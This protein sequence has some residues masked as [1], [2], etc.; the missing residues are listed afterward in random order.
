MPLFGGAPAQKESIMDMI[1]L[2]ASS[3]PDFCD[4]PARWEAK[5]IKG[6]R[7]PTSY[8]AYL[9]TCVHAGTAEYDLSKVNGATAS[10]KEL[11]ESALEV[12]HGTL[13][14]PKEDIE[15]DDAT[16]EGIEPIVL[17]LV[18]MYIAQIAPKMDYVAV[19]ATCKDLPL[20]DLG[21]ILTGTTDRI[22]QTAADEYGIADLK[23]GGSAVASDG[24]V[25]TTPHAMQMGVYEVLAEASTGLPITAPAHII[26]L[27]TAKTEKGRRVGIGTIEGAKD[28]LLGSAEEPGVLE[29]VSRL[30]HSGTFLGNPKS[31][32]CS[33]KFCPAY[34]ACRFRH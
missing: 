10:D 29:I 26:G 12:A 7:N 30:I 5:Y 31:S 32:V 18:K 16:P 34:N 15:W 19:E 14:A 17:S 33:E 4:C 8:K 27:Q 9:G 25:K 13:Y 23:T 3:L 6:M 24:T 28:M 21:L 2:R 22:Y 1:K 20:E 11:L